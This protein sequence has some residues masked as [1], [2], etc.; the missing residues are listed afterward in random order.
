MDFLQQLRVFIAVAE[1]RSFRRAAQALQMTRPR[2]THAIRLLEKTVGARLLHRTTR[3]TSLTG[4]GELMLSRATALLA[5]ADEA[6]HLFGGPDDAPK[7]RLRIDCAVAL[8]RPLLVPALP[9]FRRA[10]PDVDLVL[11]V[12]DQPIDLVADA[13]DCVLRIGKLAENSMIARTLVR[14]T[15]VICASP[16]YLAA[17]GT[18]TSLADLA[19]HEAINYFFGRGHRPMD[20]SI[21]DDDGDRAVRLAGAIRVNDAG[22]LVD[23]ALAGMGLAQVPGI[24]VEEHL[25]EGRLVQVLPGL[26]GTSLPASIMYPSRRFLAEMRSPWLQPPSGGAD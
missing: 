24:L 20:W 7:G 14:L 8:V 19:D 6:A 11:G 26:S 2:V 25:A 13:L 1:A 4:E 22:T 3:H 10:Y 23:C 18:P 12:S 15:M 21:A 17:R 16:G 5:D 9:G